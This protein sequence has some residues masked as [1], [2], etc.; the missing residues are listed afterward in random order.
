MKQV[1]RGEGKG[2]GV[3]DD[4]GGEGEIGILKGKI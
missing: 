4:E 2:L 3:S 1:S